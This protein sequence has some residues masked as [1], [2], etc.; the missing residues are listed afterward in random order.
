M[1]VADEIEQLECNEKKWSE[2]SIN[3]FDKY[4]EKLNKRDAFLAPY[5]REIKKYFEITKIEMKEIK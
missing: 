4:I 1:Q 2:E 5:L 3:E